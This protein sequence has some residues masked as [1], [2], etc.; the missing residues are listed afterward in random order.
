MIDSLKL[1][2]SQ[3]LIAISDIHAHAAL[4]HALLAQ[5]RYD[6]SDALVLMGDFLER[7]NEGLST[8]RAIMDL[9]SRNPDVR[10]LLGNWD[11]SMLKIIESGDAERIWRY[12]CA[13]KRRGNDTIIGEMSAECGMELKDARDTAHAVGV[14]RKKYADILDFIRSLPVVLDAQDQIFVHG[15]IP[16]ED[17]DRLDRS[18]V[19]QYLKDDAF[20]CAD[21]CFSKTV[22]VGHIPVVNFRLRRQLADPFFDERRN[23]IGIDGGCGVKRDGQINALIWQDGK[24]SFQSACELPRI[25]ALCSQAG[26][27]GTV[28]SRYFEPVEI[29]SREGNL[30]RLRHLPTGRIL[31]TTADSI[32]SDA[33]GIHSEATDEVLSV[34]AGEEFYLIERTPRGIL[35]KKGGVTGWYYGAWE[36]VRA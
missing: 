35:A 22:V 17:L 24:Y 9:K 27:E 18:N 20:Y 14:I 29:L 2:P 32:F 19:Y 16:H 10:P 23:I 7:G 34:A 21:S 31:W 15:G 25:R 30:A 26:F 5:I 3:R 8:I 13:K 6:A 12:I 4:L 1:R 28:N 33:D 36:S 11:Y